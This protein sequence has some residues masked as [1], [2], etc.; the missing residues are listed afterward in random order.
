MDAKINYYTNDDHNDLKKS[1]LHINYF[2]DEI[3]YEVGHPI[4]NGGNSTSNS[5]ISK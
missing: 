2:I 5:P 1:G 3:N 4:R